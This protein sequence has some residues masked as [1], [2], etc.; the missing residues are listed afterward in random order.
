MLLVNARLLFISF[1]LWYKCLPNQCLPL[2]DDWSLLSFTSCNSWTDLDL[3]LFI[4][5]EQDQTR[6]SF[7]QYQYYSSQKK[8]FRK[9]SIL[10]SVQ[11]IVALIT[12]CANMV[13]HTYK[14]WEYDIFQCLCIWVLACHFFNQL[15][16]LIKDRA[17]IFYVCEGWSQPI[18]KKI[19]YWYRK[20]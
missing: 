8:F 4:E 12:V 19:W 9:C 5:T 11:K 2:F 6:L 15:K 18:A 16:L 14:R 7:I 13:K 20:Y 1:D 3:Q 17:L 10:H